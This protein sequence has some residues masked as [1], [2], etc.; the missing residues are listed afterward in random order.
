MLLPALPSRFVSAGV[1]K[2]YRFNCSPINAAILKVGIW[3]DSILFFG[4]S[5]GSRVRGILC[6][7]AVGARFPFPGNQPVRP[8]VSCGR[9]SAGRRAP[10]SR[11][12]ISEAPSVQFCTPILGFRALVRR[13]AWRS[14]RTRFGRMRSPE[15]TDRR[16]RRRVSWDVSRGPKAAN[17]WADR[18]NPLIALATQR[19]SL[20]SP[21]AVFATCTGAHPN[22]PETP[23]REN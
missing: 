11:W 7:V 2:Q 14:R 4:F 16:S 23:H 17:C 20:R 15:I 9:R 1:V 8:A 18:I 13:R 10:V 12:M 6:R 3:A 22:L 5:A 19:H 21:A